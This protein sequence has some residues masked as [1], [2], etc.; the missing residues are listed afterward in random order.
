MRAEKLQF[1][2]IYGIVKTHLKF[3][4]NFK[5]NSQVSLQKENLYCISRAAEDFSSD[6]QVDSEEESGLYFVDAAEASLIKAPK[7]SFI[8][9]EFRNYK[10][11]LDFYRSS[12]N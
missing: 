7:F 9:Q 10:N 1:N 11:S 2:K 12:L 3:S 5:L 4:E 6:S 8:E